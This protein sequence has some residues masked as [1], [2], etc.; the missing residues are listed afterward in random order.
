MARHRRRPADPVRHRRT[1]T[2]QP[3]SARVASCESPRS[4]DQPDKTGNIMGLAATAA[5]RPRAA[6]ED[7]SGRAA[8]AT[9]PS[10]AH[11]DD[12]IR[13]RH[14]DPS[15]TAPTV[16]PRRKPVRRPC[17][18]DR[19]GT[20]EANP[21]HGGQRTPGT[22]ESPRHAV[23]GGRPPGAGRSTGTRR[24]RDARN[25]PERGCSDAGAPP[26]SPPSRRLPALGAEPS[27]PA[28]LDVARTPPVTLRHTPPSGSCR[29]GR[30]ASRLSR[31]GNSA[32]ATP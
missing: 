11:R 17:G 25:Q 30:F 13:P 4:F 19:H 12:A 24:S 14:T 20:Q 21:G 6:L 3:T 18:K 22:R 16:H 23:V 31:R 10:T 26:A 29:P 1:L 5:V 9:T 2:N 8:P 27:G 7:A 15:R 32:R 28:E